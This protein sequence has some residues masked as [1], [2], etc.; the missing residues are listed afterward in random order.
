MGLLKI[1]AAVLAALQAVQAVPTPDVDEEV[2]VS[3]PGKYC[4]E[5]TT[6]CY[7]EYKTP[8]EVTFRIAIS[9]QAK[10]APFDVLLSIVAPKSIGWAGIAWG[11]VMANNPLTVGWANSDKTVVSSR[12]AT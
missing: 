12:L 10:A 8:Q 7:S 9:D 11:G 6:I 1:T 3:A 2:G 4:D 5:A